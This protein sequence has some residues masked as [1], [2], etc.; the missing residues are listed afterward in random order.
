M[1]KHFLRVLIAVLFLLVSGFA[2][3]ETSPMSDWE[4]T[5]SVTLNGREFYS[6]GFNGFSGSYREQDGY[7]IVQGRK[8]HY[9]L[10]DTYAYHNGRGGA[11]LNQVIP[12]W[13]ESMG[14]V[15][16]FD[17]IKKYNPNT[18]LANS[19]KALMKQ[20]GCDVSVTLITRESGN[21]TR[22]DHVV[23]NDYDK[24]KDIYRTTI[25]YLYK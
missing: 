23:I 11:I 20:R 3:A 18:N 22:T 10:Y 21:T 1:K 16:D 14:Y 19:V 17:N 13:V 9:W 4:Y 5:N 24:D 2:F 12:K 7:A 15:I 6:S 25:Y 8:L